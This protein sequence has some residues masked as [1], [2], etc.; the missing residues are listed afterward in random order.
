MSYWEGIGSNLGVCTHDQSK[1]VWNL[2]RYLLYFVVFASREKRKKL[3]MY[4]YGLFNA[5]DLYLHHQHYSPFL[6]LSPYV[7][8]EERVKNAEG[9]IRE[10]NLKILIEK[11]KWDPNDPYANNYRPDLDEGLQEDQ[12]YSADPDY[13]W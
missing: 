7:T 6:P 11:F 4:W 1:E 12:D 8:E 2:E 10:Y 9:L 5:I 13:V 3:P